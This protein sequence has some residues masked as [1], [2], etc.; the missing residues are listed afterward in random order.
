M[1]VLYSGSVFNVSFDQ[2]RIVL[3]FYFFVVVVGV[4]S[5]KGIGGG[6]FFGYDV[7]VFV[8]CY[9]G[10]EVQVKVNGMGY[11]SQCFFM[12]VIDICDFLLVILIDYFIFDR[13]EI[14]KLGLFLYNLQFKCR[15]FVNN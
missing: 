8:L 15:K 7:D 13:V 14:D 4:I 3:G 11:M 5:Q 12:D 6:Y 1:R 9:V 10:V 2:R